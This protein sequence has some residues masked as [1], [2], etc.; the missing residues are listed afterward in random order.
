VSNG[1]IPHETCMAINRLHDA[2]VTLHYDPLG[3]E[4]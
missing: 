2:S 1:I 3:L 4:K